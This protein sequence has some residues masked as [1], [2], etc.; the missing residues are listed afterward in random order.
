MSVD[1]ER[2]LSDLEQW[3]ADMNIVNALTEERRKNTDEKF[4]GINKRFDKIDKNVS[5]LLFLVAA[6][7]IAAVINF[8][9]QGGLTVGG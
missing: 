8:I 1:L 9:V 6:G 5:K 2:R 7:I 4:E 3:R